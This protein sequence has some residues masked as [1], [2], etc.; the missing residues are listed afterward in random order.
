MRK[1]S[2]IILLAFGIIFIAGGGYYALNQP[3]NIEHPQGQKTSLEVELVES[4]IA[5]QLFYIPKPYLD[6]GHTSVG[7]KSA[8]IQAF[9]PGSH[10]V[11]GDPKKLWEEGEWDKNVRILFTQTGELQ[12]IEPLIEKA[13]R[14]FYYEEYMNTESLK[15]AVYPSQPTETIYGLAHYPATPKDFKDIYLAEDEKGSKSFIRCSAKLTEKSVPQCAHNF[16]FENFRFKVSYDKG[17]LPLWAIIQ[18]NTLQLYESFKA[19]DSAATY[20]L[21]IKDNQTH[22]ELKHAD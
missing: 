14:R 7:E 12:T 18:D 6:F 13:L 1:I 8:L 9:Y 10:P 20:F 4:N 16:I 15:R 17:L 2:K 11:P 3:S 22:G 19:P 5:G 21:S